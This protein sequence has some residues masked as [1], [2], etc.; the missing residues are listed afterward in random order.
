MSL[1]GPD[2]SQT[3]GPCFVYRACAVGNVARLFTR[4]C[5]AAIE[6]RTSWAQPLNV[7]FEIRGEELVEELCHLIP[8]PLVLLIPMQVALTFC[9]L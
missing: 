9:P 1:E 7:S 5:Y 4:N 8:A 2:C 3:R 6:R